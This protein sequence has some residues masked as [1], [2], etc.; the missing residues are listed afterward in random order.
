MAQKNHKKEISGPIN[1]IRLEGIV[2]GIKKVITLFMDIHLDEED[3]T[4]CEGDAPEIKK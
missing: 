4:K 1:V 3:Q 2:N